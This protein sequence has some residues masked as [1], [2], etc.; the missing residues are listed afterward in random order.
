[1]ADLR[2]FTGLSEGMAPEDVFELLNRHL[3]RMSDVILE[4]DGTINDFIGDE[5]MVVFGMPK[6]RP[7][8]PVR[9]VAC[10]IAMQNELRRLNRELLADDLPTLEMGIGLNTGQVLL[11]NIGSDKRLKYGIVGSAVN[12]A[13]RIQADATGGQ[14]FLG[15]PTFELV[16]EMVT[17]TEHHTAWMKGLSQPLL[18]H[19][20]T[21]V[22]PPYD[23]ELEPTTPETAEIELSGS[24]SWWRGGQADRRTAR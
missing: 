6:H 14:V 2:G 24:C 11:G 13:A 8:D 3:S 21:A 10:A 7:D 12:T 22:G 20:V 15:Q 1:M 5:F 16:R 9:A 17:A 23:I 4:Y 18:I 19:S